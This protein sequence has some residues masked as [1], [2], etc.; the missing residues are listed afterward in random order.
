MKNDRV[1]LGAGLDFS[2][3]T[4]MATVS[5]QLAYR[6]KSLNLFGESSVYRAVSWMFLWPRLAGLPVSCPELHPV[7]T[8]HR[9]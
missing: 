1:W 5:F 9:R 3:L 4:P 2:I 6:Q 8:G 7:L